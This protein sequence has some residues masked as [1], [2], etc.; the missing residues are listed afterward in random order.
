[1]TKSLASHFRVLLMQERLTEVFGE[2]WRIFLKVS[3]QMK[4]LSFR[5]C[6]VRGDMQSTSV[7]Y[8]QCLKMWIGQYQVEIVTVLR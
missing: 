2:Q 3:I 4:G 7:R 1:M 6:L 5:V 8:Q